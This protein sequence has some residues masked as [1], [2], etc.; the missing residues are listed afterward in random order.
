V[1]AGRQRRSLASG[2]LPID[3]SGRSRLSEHRPVNEKP[4]VEE[5]LVYALLAIPIFLVTIF[6]VVLLALLGTAPP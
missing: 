3:S 6:I 1:Q 4:R 5:H 2:T